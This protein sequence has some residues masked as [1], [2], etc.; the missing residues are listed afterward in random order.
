MFRI[1]SCALKIW[2]KSVNFVIL[3]QTICRP[4]QLQSYVHNLALED[5]LRDKLIMGLADANMQQSWLSK[6]DLSFEQ[7]VDIASNAELSR[8]EQKSMNNSVHVK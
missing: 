2:Q 7:C 1:L 8:Q 6:K 5:A 3:S 4:Q